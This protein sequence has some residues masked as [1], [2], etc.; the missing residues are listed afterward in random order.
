MECA[1]H[2]SFRARA[3]SLWRC[4]AACWVHTGRRRAARALRRRARLSGLQRTTNEVE[5][6]VPGPRSAKGCRHLQV[7][8]LLGSRLVIER[9]LGS[10]LVASANAAQEPAVLIEGPKARVRCLR[11]RGAPRPLRSHRP[12]DDNR[13]V[14]SG[15]ACR[16][17]TGASAPASARQRQ[18]GSWAPLPGQRIRNHGPTRMR[19]SAS[20]VGHV[21]DLT[22]STAHAEGAQDPWQ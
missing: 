19:V 14:W 17:L 1:Q 12:H 22:R 7:P 9:R 21:I 13:P 4:L 3:R 18:A 20:L 15:R 5:K 10:N 6:L 11:H 2:Q 8:S 16:P